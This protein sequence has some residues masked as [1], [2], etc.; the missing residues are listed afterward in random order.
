MTGNEKQ[1]TLKTSL[2]KKNGAVM[3]LSRFVLLRPSCAVWCVVSVY[4][5]RW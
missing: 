3:L 5:R 2:R 1:W 4:I